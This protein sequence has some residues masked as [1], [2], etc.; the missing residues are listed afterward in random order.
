[1]DKVEEAEEHILYVAEGLDTLARSFRTTG[2]L[3]LAKS[4]ADFSDL[5]E[6][7]VRTLSESLTELNHARYLDSQQASIN[8]LNAVLAGAELNKR[9]KEN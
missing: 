1:M 8:V 3:I 5:L 2:N 6:E 4:L 7:S 9:T